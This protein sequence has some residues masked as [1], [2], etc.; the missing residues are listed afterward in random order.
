[1]NIQEKGFHSLDRGYQKYKKGWGT[2][3]GQK[4]GKSSLA[5]EEGKTCA[6]NGVTQRGVRRTP[7][8]S[9]S[10]GTMTGHCR[11]IREDMDDV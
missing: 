11:V 4:V 8:R 9:D 6:D 3:V 5:E 1:M 7:V 10:F 2:F